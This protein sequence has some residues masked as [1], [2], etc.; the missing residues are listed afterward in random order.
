ML[1]PV[2][3]VGALVFI[4]V[5]IIALVRLRPVR[6]F[7]LAAAFTI[8][9]MAGFFAGL[10]AGSPLFGPFGGDDTKLIWLFSF[11]SFMAIA[12]GVIAAWLL[13]KLGGQSP[14]RRI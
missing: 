1:A 8:G 2:I 4:P 14:W 7:V 13:G 11:A 3:V 10:L 9:A 6:A 12:G 5:L